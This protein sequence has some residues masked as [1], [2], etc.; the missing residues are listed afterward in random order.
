MCLLEC[1]REEASLEGKNDF[2][3]DDDDDI[4]LDRFEDPFKT[5]DL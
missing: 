1:D 4:Y 5:I 3:P 2:Y